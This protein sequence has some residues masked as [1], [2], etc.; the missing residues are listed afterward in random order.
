MPTF[1][2]P[3]TQ[4]HEHTHSP[5]NTYSFLYILAQAMAHIRI[6]THLN[7]HAQTNTLCIP[8]Y[9]THVHTIYTHTYQTSSYIVHAHT[10]THM[11][12]GEPGS[13][14]PQGLTSGR[15]ETHSGTGVA[16]M[17]GVSS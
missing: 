16:T 17:P 13:D 15:G 6:W 9:Y 5:T 14:G 12:S 11:P 7:I 10:Y 3:C 1:T 4:T 2:Y 8:T